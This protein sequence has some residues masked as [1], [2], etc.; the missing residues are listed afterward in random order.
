MRADVRNR[1]DGPIADIINFHAGQ[2][3]I[4]ALS[5]AIAEVELARRKCFAAPVIG[6][7]YKKVKE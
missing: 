4:T 7:A 1:R 6:L 5:Q 3:P 2:S